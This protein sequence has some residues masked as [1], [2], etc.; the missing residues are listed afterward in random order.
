MTPFSISTPDRSERSASV[1]MP[2]NGP[3]RWRPA[4]LIDSWRETA[5]ART[6]VFDVA[7]WPG[8]DGG[9][10]VDIK[11]TG[12]DGYSA[13]R[14]YSIASASAQNRVELTVQLVPRGEVSPY[15]VEIMKTGDELELR[16]PIGGWFRWTEA[17]HNPVLLV[18]GGSG[19]VPLMAM[20]RQ[21]VRSGST[22]SFRMIYTVRTPDQVF[23][24]KE[25]NT[26]SRAAP[27]ITI[28]RIYTRSGLGS[29]GRTPGRLTPA[30][31]PMADPSATTPTRVYVCGPTGFVENAAEHILARGHQA[32]VIR[33]ER[34]GP[35]G[36]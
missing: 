22:A 9:Q 12:E 6:L 23:Y 16:G 11:L 2:R 15:L 34:F 21:R 25:L 1:G 8:H 7:D 32:Q 36:G 26:L 24:V 31:V 3:I 17:L 19:I 14:S 29:D 30:D 5:T 10:H 33:T 28:Q 27:D 13:Q 35:S 4:R 20:L 18:G